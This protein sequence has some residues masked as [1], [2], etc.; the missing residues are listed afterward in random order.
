[1]GMSLLLLF[2]ACNQPL[3]MLTITIA[4]ITFCLS[5]VTLV[6]LAR[7]Q[8][9]DFLIVDAARDLGATKWQAFWKIEMPLLAPGILAGGLLAF[10]LSIDDFVVTF[11]VKGPGAD[12]L[13]VVIYSMIKKSREFP[14]IN[15]LSTL[16]LLVT[17]LAVW[18]AQR[19]TAKKD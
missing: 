14:V 9:F 4:H 19:L 1:M 8:D 3:G 18:G 6:V 7:L 17:F 12:T 13:P 10:T 11:F 2:V 5:Y 15:A 16:L